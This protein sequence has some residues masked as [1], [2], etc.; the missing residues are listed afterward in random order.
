M[1]IVQVTNK[2]IIAFTQ[3]KKSCYI[4]M[5]SQYLHPL[6]EQWSYG[7]KIFFNFN[8]VKRENFFTHFYKFFYD[9]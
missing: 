1:I 5:L 6:K 3:Q 9:F 4:L 8:F 7:S 2:V